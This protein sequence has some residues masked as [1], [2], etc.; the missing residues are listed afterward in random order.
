MKIGPFLDATDGVTAETGLGGN[1]GNIET[2]VRISKN[3]GAFAP[4][5]SFED[6]IHD[7]DGWYDLELD[8]TDTNFV[9]LLIVQCHD[10]TT[11]Q[12]VWHEFWVL[13]GDL[14]NTL[15]GSEIL[16]TNVTRWLHE[17]VATP[18][19][20][21]VPEVDVSHWLGTEIPGVDTDGYPK[22]TIK[23]GQGAGELD[24]S[25]GYVLAAN[26]DPGRVWYVDDD[27]GAG[28]T[29]TREAPFGTINEAITAAV[30]GDTIFV[31]P[32]TY[33][34]ANVTK[35]GLTIVG[36]TGGGGV[37]ITDSDGAPMAINANVT[38]TTLRRLTVTNSGTSGAGIELLGNCHNTL[39]EECNV[40]GPFDGFIASGSTTRNITLRRSRFSSGINAVFIVGR[41]FLID[42]CWITTSAADIA[43]SH[44]LFVS[45][46]AVGTIQNCKVDIA[47]PNSTVD[48]TSGIEIGSNA[49][50]QIVA[51][52]VSATSSH[53]GSLGPTAGITQNLDNPIF[54][55]IIGGRIVT[56]KAGDGQEYSINASISGSRVLVL[57]TVLD[58]T[59]I[60]GASNV[61]YLD[62][63]VVDGLARTM[64][65]L[66]SAT[67]AANGGLAT[68][69][70]NN[71]IA[72]IQGATNRFDDLLADAPDFD[73]AMDAHGYTETRADALDNLDARVSEAGSVI[74]SPTTIA[75]VVSPTVIRLTEGSNV[76]DAYTDQLVV[77]TDA[78]NSNAPCVRKCTDYVGGAIREITLESAPNFTVQQGDGVKILANADVSGP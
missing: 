14:F 48:V 78:S 65:A 44:A 15:T 71:R 39:V 62:Q 70:A 21:G 10:S 29:G 30:S 51:T 4:R 41:G 49:F 28:D 25:N 23:D 69:D 36:A 19:V 59:K 24:L 26:G 33:D 43:D 77:L 22:V 38:G 52:D 72:G 34:T 17:P 35:S 11:Y 27:E 63:N 18:T 2:N 57:G 58:Q 20:A 50:V 16:Q 68:V 9:G 12:Q 74:D 32:G 75:T 53:V 47:Q 5:H 56:S 42:S 37:T 64:L 60:N 3:D 61:F 13:P 6:P 73:E 40:T 45:S 67:P 55:T 76:D 66:P 46:S 31:M 1:G 8:E 54:C 7:E